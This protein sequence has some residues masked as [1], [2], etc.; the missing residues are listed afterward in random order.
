MD[1]SSVKWNKERFDEIY[2]S[3][4]SFIQNCGFNLEKDVI[5]LPCSGLS[6]DNLTKQVE[7]K[8]CNWYQ[9]PSFIDVLNDIELPKRD[10]SG[11]LRIPLLDKMKDRGT[12]VF[13]KVESGTINL[14]DK[15]SLYPS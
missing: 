6:G 7:K 12:V 13:G 1:E 3:M 14:G 8:V 10:A 15:L 11:P 4:M 9:G 5:W 2:N